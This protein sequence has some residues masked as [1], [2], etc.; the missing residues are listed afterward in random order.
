MAEFNT[1]YEI[2][3]KLTIYANSAGDAL[4]EAENRLRHPEG[5]SRDARAL[6]VRETHAK[7]VGAAK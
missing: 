3:I 7:R 2:T 6:L 5:P 4:T 1:E